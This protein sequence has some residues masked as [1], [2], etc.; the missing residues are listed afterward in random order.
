MRISSNNMD[1]VVYSDTGRD[2]KIRHVMKN[3]LAS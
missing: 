2:G 3:K 1:A